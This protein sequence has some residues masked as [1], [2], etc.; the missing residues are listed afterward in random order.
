[1]KRSTAALIAVGCGAGL[2]LS[3]IG[4]NYRNELDKSYAM[5]VHNGGNVHYV[6]ESIDQ[7]QKSLE[8]QLNVQVDPVVSRDGQDL[9]TEDIV[10]TGDVVRVSV[11]GKGTAN[12][13]IVVKGDVQGTGKPGLGQVSTV[14]KALSGDLEL[15][16]VEMMAADVDNSGAVELADL[17]T[18]TEYASKF[19]D[20][21]PDVNI[22]PRSELAVEE[23]EEAAA[24]SVE[25]PLTD[26]AKT[27]QT[28]ILDATNALRKENGQGDL[29]LDSK[30]TWAAQA[31]AEE[32]AE[33]G[34]FEHVRPDGSSVETVV[35]FDGPSSFG[36][37][38]HRNKG[39]GA[40][41]AQIAMDRFTNSPE[42]YQN[43]VGPDYNYI[44]IGIAQDAEGRWIICQ[45]FSSSDKIMWVDYPESYYPALAGALGNE[46]LEEAPA[47]Q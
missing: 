27:F 46:Y 29:T 15:D 25:T 42:H 21:N 39:Y 33:S 32:I 9:G 36:E 38:L 41:T 14:A 12:Y 8:K 43:L 17:M 10:A 20:P 16:P 5:L 28:E 13:R 4:A 1:M 37:N 45:L 2:T 11:P 30:L 40:Q 19:V 6:S 35:E 22:E 44:G 47:A 31:R 23:D 34:R 7:V 18:I 3:I 24:E 26:E